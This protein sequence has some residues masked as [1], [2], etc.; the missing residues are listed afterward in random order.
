MWIKQK[1]D[2]NMNN[3]HNTM[4]RLAL[5]VAALA[6]P[7]L[8]FAQ[9]IEFQTE[10]LGKMI[11]K[12]NEPRF[13]GYADNSVVM[14]DYQ[15]RKAIVTRYDMSQN[16]LASAELGSKKEI[17]NYGGFINGDHVDLLNVR[18]SNGGMHVYRDRRSLRTLEPEGTPLTLAEYKGNS[19][20]KYIFTLGTSPDQNLL[21]GVTVVAR[22]SFDPEVKVALYN[23]E[24]E[25]YWHMPVRTSGFNQV[26]VNDSGE[27]VLALCTTSTK[28]YNTFTIVDGEN[29]K[30]VSFKLK[31]DG[32]PMECTLLRYGNGKLILAVAVREENHTIMPI[33]SNI[34]R[35]DFYC[36]NVKNDEITISSH[37]FTDQECNRM[38]NIKEQK[39]QKH[40]WVQ[41]GNIVQGIAD[42][43]GAYLMFDQTWTVTKNDIPVEQHRLGMM[44]LRVD[45]EGRVQWVRAIR[46]GAISS[47]GGRGMIAY[48]WRRTP[49]GIVLAAAQHIKNFDLTDDQNIRPVKAMKDKSMLNVIT[50]DRTGR[51]KRQNFE[52][53]KQSVM[54]APHTIDDNSFMLLLAGGG[55]GQF[56][57]LSIK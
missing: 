4:K 31:D 17:D 37:N 51:T 57:R 14:V 9:N 6:L 35:M 32:R 25:E 54:G 45:S 43:N 40:H 22:K 12:T 26:L 1:N 8:A 47:W 36:Y 44:V 16:V 53:G 42:D 15:S 56:A 46:M 10:A 50:I 52:I 2:N 21:A 33:G 41:F 13:I 55:K 38:A 3:R 28:K 7:L 11:A 49:N 5:T 19:D 24:L 34:D 48:R 30:Q 39:S 29:E 27:V 23:R 20:D 18:N